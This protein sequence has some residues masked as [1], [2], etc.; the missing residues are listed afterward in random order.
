MS[1]W[2]SWAVRCQLFQ[3]AIA[4]TI[5]L[6]LILWKTHTVNKLGRYF[7][8]FFK[9]SR[10]SRWPRMVVSVTTAIITVSAV[11]YA[12]EL[13]I[14]PFISGQ[15]TVSV[16]RPLHYDGNVDNLR[17]QIA[18]IECDGHPTTDDRWTYDE[19]DSNGVVQRLL[20]FKVC[21]TH[22]YVA[23]KDQTMTKSLAVRRLYLPWYYRLG[24]MEKRISL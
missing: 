13:V 5:F 10:Y 15:A 7:D 12:V 4:V 17:V 1:E 19:F 21:E 16:V 18:P 9:R 14:D 11:A 22:L 8:D 2:S 23:L 20:R 24:L 6:I 3:W